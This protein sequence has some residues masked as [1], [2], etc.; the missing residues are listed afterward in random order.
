MD[1]HERGGVGGRGVS[2]CLVLGLL[3]FSYK[4]ICTFAIFLCSIGD[5]VFIKSGKGRKRGLL[6]FGVGGVLGQL[7]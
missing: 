6:M 2:Y 3:Q 1:M 5:W 7:V 4:K